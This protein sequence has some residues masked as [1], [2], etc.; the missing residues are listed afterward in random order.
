[1]SDSGPGIPEERQAQ[2]WDQY[3]RYGKGPGLGL[4]LYIV[5]RL[6][7]AMGGTIALESRPASGTQF[8][9]SLPLEGDRPKRVSL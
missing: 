9:V 3:Q 5:R 4:G 7:E 2:I 1:V 6:T 8:S